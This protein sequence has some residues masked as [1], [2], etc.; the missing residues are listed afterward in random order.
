MPGVLIAVI[1]ATVVVGVFDLAA[2]AGVTVL[3][4]LPQGLPDF[5]IP[6]ISSAT[7]SRS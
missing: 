7:S 3:G 5:A 4:P 2:S 6:W 1:G